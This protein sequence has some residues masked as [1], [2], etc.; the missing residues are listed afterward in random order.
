M[1]GGYRIGEPAH[2]ATAGAAGVRRHEGPNGDDPDRRVTVSILE[3]DAIR[4]P[5]IVDLQSIC[6]GVAGDQDEMLVAAEDDFGDDRPP[7]VE[8]SLDD[9]QVRSRPSG[10]LDTTAGVPRD[11]IPDQPVIEGIAPIASEPAV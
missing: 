7:G 8:L 5:G 2:P 1:Q 9:T 10:K 11:R 6:G 4:K 3:V